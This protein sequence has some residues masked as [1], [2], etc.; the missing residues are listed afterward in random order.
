MSV[1][2]Y[3]TFIL[4][5]IWKSN[6]SKP[7]EEEYAKFKK[8]FDQNPNWRGTNLEGEF[9]LSYEEVYS[10]KDDMLS[11][12]KEYQYFHPYVRKAIYGYEDEIVSN[13]V[14]RPELI[15]NK[16]EYHIV[17]KE[18]Y[19]K[20][21]LNA[22]RLK[23]Y[24]TGVAL[25][26]MECENHGIDGNGDPQNSLNA[27]K[28]I[29]DYGRRI[30]IP[31]IDPNYAICADKLWVQFE[32]S[33]YE[34]DFL[35]TMKSVK[36]EQ[37]LLTRVSLTNICEVIK[38]FLEEGSEYSFSSRQALDEKSFFV[39]PA[40]DDRMFVACMVSDE[41]KTQSML[42]VSEVGDQRRYAY[43]Q[44]EDIQKEL[45]E[46]VFVDPAGDCTMQEYSMRAQYLEER[47]YKR[48]FD[49]NSIYSITNQSM[50]MLSSASETNCP[51][52]I[53]NFLTQ[54]VQ[55]ACLGLAQRASLVKFK[56]EVSQLSAV[57]SRKKI[58]DDN[59]KVI[60]GLQK[61]Y[62]A[63]Q[64]QLSFDE[65]SPQEQG[66]EMYQLLKNALYIEKESETVKGQIEDLYETANTSLNYELS[67]VANVFLP[68]TVFLSICGFVFDHIALEDMEYENLLA[69][70]NSQ[71]SVTLKG[72]MT[73]FFGLIPILIGGL[74]VFLTYRIFR[75]IILKE[76]I[77][78][79]GIKK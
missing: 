23:I 62:V 42:R 37:D 6:N 19:Y 54:Y 46:L 27:V 44:N 4:P 26:I 15:R 36:G 74:V 52:L 57:L 55:M 30:T 45:Y 53:D 13:Y 33:R 38:G 17:K 48:W 28:D 7:V 9:K 21:M 72:I 61:R 51:F 40:L 69:Y 18:K 1:Y 73:L 10:T 49:Y 14:F 58:E 68:L 25:F 76:N 60:M 20:L 12:Y 35:A 59:I 77:L 22:I 63:Y 47:L 43:E 70:L 32:N 8:N 24:N 31:F 34:E 11:L 29:N 16:A 65:V 2:S 41:E 75:F 39:Y 56:Y 64:S 50:I 5:F 67:N 79:K 78:R 71:S 3:H 66:I